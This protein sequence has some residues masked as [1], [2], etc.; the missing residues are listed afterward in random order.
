MPNISVRNVPRETYDAIR[1]LAERERRS[2]QQQVLILLEAARVL[3][4]A[5]DVMA[6]A[7]SLRERFAERDLTDP[8]ELIAAGRPGR[9]IRSSGWCRETVHR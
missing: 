1:R 2:L 7:A 8:V 4:P 9:L 6:R 5:P 3:A